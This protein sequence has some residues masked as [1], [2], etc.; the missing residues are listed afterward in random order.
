[1]Y[2]TYFCC[3]CLSCYI[4]VSITPTLFCLVACPLKYHSRLRRVQKVLARITVYIRT[5][6]FI[7]GIYTGDSRISFKLSTIT[8][9]ALGSSRPSLLQNHSSPQ[10][11][12]SSSAKLLTVPRNNLSFGSHVFFRISDPTTWTSLPQNIREC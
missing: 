8:S 9:K 3:Y 2:D 7:F 5:P 10:T 6:H 11:M 4:A 1:M 12:R